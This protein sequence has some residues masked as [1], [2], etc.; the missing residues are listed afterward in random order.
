MIR[1][2]SELASLD[3]EKNCIGGLLKYPEVFP[4]ID[5]RINTTDFFNDQHRQIY[6]VLKQSLYKK[7]LIDS[8]VLAQKLVNLGLI[9]F[10]DLNLADYLS[11]IAFTA[12]SKEGVIDCFA[13]LKKL[14]VCRELTENADRVK[15]F[16]F[17]NR[18]KEISEIVTGVDGIHNKKIEIINLND[19]DPVDL[20]GD[21]KEVA[22]KAAENPVSMVGYQTGLT[23]FDDLTGGVRAG[24]GIYV[25]AARA[26]SGKSS[27]L[28]NMAQ[29]ISI[30][31]DC[32]SL[33]IDTEM[34]P[35]L[36]KNR[37]ISAITQCPL[38][39]IENGQWKQMAEYRDKVEKELDKYD[40]LKGKIFHKYVGLMP[41]PEVIS[42]IK[43]WYYKFVGRGN[44]CFVIYDYLKIS[45]VTKNWAEFQAIGDSV[46]RFN[47]LGNQLDIPI[48]AA[49][50]QNRNDLGINKLDNESSV[51][52][53]DRISWFTQGLFLFR[54]KTPEEIT[55][56]GTKFGRNLLKPLVFRT[57]GKCESGINELVRVRDGKQIKYLPNFINYD[58]NNFKITEHGTYADIIKFLQQKPNV[59]N[60]TTEEGL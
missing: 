21:L 60:P 3:I 11:S 29:G 22:Q 27:W 47:D 28:L 46:C 34:R 26:K 12:I 37:A 8:A 17:K 59:S 9:Q 24:D 13:E 15:E 52:I 23:L 32:P 18:S 31:N 56:W 51:A 40:Y 6:A 33:I 41:V 7:E 10:G 25:V 5:L 45:E 4:E 30:Q 58:V 19:D 50:Q 54:K 16:I 42:L 43:R 53:S 2:Q 20:Y 55:S 35:M 49:C 39:Y 36:I 48:F 44:K 1:K 38:P 57:Y 14:A